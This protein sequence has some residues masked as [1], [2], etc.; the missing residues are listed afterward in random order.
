MTTAIDKLKKANQKSAEQADAVSVGSVGDLNDFKDLLN[1]TTGE[2]NFSNFRRLSKAVKAMPKGKKRKKAINLI[3]KRGVAGKDA[4][5]V[6]AVL[7]K[8]VD[9]KKTAPEKAAPEG[10]TLKQEDR[11]IME[12]LLKSREGQPD[13]L[14]STAVDY[15]GYIWYAVRGKKNIEFFML[16]ASFKVPGLVRDENNDNWALL[17]QFNDRDG[18]AAECTFSLGDIHDPRSGV[19]YS[20][21]NMGMEIVN[22]EKFISLLE[23][24]NTDLRLRS[25]DAAGWSPH[26]DFVSPT[27]E[28]FYAEG[29]PASD[30]NL[31]LKEGHGYIDGKPAGT[32]EMSES[33]LASVL[34]TGNHHIT[35]AI[36]MNL[37]GPLI[38]LLKRDSFMMLFFGRSSSGKSTGQMLGASMWATLEPGGGVFTNANKTE[39]S[40]IVKVANTSAT[41][42]NFDEMGNHDK[43]L[44]RMAFSVSSNE[45]RSRLTRSGAEQK[46]LRIWRN[47]ITASV[48]KS[49]LVAIA[50]SGGEN[51]AGRAVRMISVN[52][53]LTREELPPATLE[54]IGKA[55]QNYGH[56]GPAFIKGM[57]A[58]GYSIQPERVQKLIEECRDIILAGDANPER[59]SGTFKR[60]AENLGVAMAAGKLA[61]EFGLFPA[62]TRLDEAFT[63]SWL[64]FINS[65]EGAVL[66]VGK[67]TAHQVIDNYMKWSHK[68][69][70]DITADGAATEDLHHDCWGY[71]EGRQG[72]LPN[73]LFIPVTT[74]DNFFEGGTREET[75]IELNDMGALVVPS[76]ASP[77]TTHKG[78]PKVNRGAHH[79]RLDLDN[80]LGGEKEKKSRANTKKKKP[81]RFVSQRSTPAHP[82]HATRH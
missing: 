11:Q 72:N 33:I 74:F 66:D 52:V 79:Y 59:K 76:D 58:E 3:I 67:S 53:S 34:T 13:W 77:L 73:L 14:R 63:T 22:K 40:A 75:L 68:H 46:G 29:T 20:L 28:V 69:I 27:G 24:I 57:I 21:L 81:K 65:R 80:L 9:K 78:I 37:A 55:K 49:P 50:K 60:A 18:Q 30:R 47:G 1:E 16:S 2:I 35:L 41:A 54:L 70:A 42:C 4:E 15:K 38:D 51:V 48:E 62:D 25:L 39:N 8:E 64:N 10:A 44:A 61:V 6:K 36:C 12:K 82:E 31:I 17:I 45:G 5:K 23:L 43:E 26:G 7:N 71:T 19:V 56:V 32:K